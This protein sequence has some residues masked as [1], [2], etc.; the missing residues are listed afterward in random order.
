MA[1]VEIGKEAPDFTLRD[2]SN[3][4]VT[5]SAL[6]GQPV[7]LVF[8]PLAFSPMCTTEMCAYR[9]DYSA[10]EGKGARI[11]GISRDSV[12]TQRAF[13][14][15]EGLKHSL[16]ADMKGQVAKLYGCWNEAAGIAERL[17]VVIDS[18]GIVR[19]FEHNGPGQIRDEK[20]ALA[21]L[22]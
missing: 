16:L 4:E 5:L 12:W 15:K 22:A 18:A 19:F 8:F 17:T 13:K 10:F 6:R 2:E 9:D 1:T 20:Q 21:A 3:H 11:F 14:E 7:V